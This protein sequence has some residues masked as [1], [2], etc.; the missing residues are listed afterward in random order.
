MSVCVCIYI[1]TYILFCSNNKTTRQNKK[2]SG[3]LDGKVHWTL[4]N[5][6]KS[7][8]W[9]NVVRQVVTAMVLP[10]WWITINTVFTRRCFIVLL[11]LH[12][13]SCRNRCVV[14]DAGRYHRLWH[15]LSTAAP[16]RRCRRRRSLLTALDHTDMGR[17]KTSI[18]ALSR[19]GSCR[20]LC[21]STDI[22][23]TRRLGDRCLGDRFLD[24]N[25]GDTGWTFRRQQSD[26]WAAINICSGRGFL[27]ASRLQRR[28]S[29]CKSVLER[30][31]TLLKW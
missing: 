15:S 1:H 6:L 8:S 9:L 22:W 11:R 4:T 16:W 24:D 7:T 26:V 14:V 17:Q 10:L 20:I 23:A 25:L 31:W 29:L 3:E 30:L 28:F 2:T 13:W 27:L 5:K 12:W 19:T 18:N 21:R